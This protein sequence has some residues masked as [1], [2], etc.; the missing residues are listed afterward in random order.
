M[1]G[2][3]NSGDSPARRAGARRLDLAD[4]RRRLAGIVPLAAALPATSVRRPDMP[5][6]RFV[7]EGFCMLIAIREHYG[8][9]ARVGV[10]Q[11]QVERFK[12]LLFCL[13]SAH[14]VWE[15]EINQ[16]EAAER[17]EAIEAAS[18]LRNR[19]FT[20]AD[21][22][23]ADLRACAAFAFRNDRT[24]ERLRRFVSIYRCRRGWGFRTRRG[25]AEPPDLPAD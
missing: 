21:D 22:G 13:Q 1:S 7:E 10:T 2:T 18:Q 14:A 5:I 17:A 12:R 11:E 6:S 20:L 4:H 9:L 23:A 8:A 19:L 3:T 25:P 24:D 16:Q 15:H